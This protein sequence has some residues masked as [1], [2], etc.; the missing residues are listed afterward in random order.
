MKV[1]LMIRINQIK[2]PI[3][4]VCPGGKTEVDPV[5][6][7]WK[8]ETK[9]RE[10]SLLKS[11]AAKLLKCRAKDI[12][13]LRIL[14]RSADARDRQEILFVYSVAVRL[15]D[16]VVGPSADTEKKFIESIR[17]RNIQQETKLPFAA[18]KPDPELIK[19]CPVP[20][21]IIGTGPCGLFAGLILAEAGLKPLILER[22]GT[23]TERVK[24]TE[25]FFDSGHLDPDC[26]IQFGEG[27]AGT[28]S[29]GKLNTSI[30]DQGGFIG[31]VLST[32][33]RFGAD[34]SILYDQ[35]PHIGTDV[36]S[37]IILKIREHIESLGGQY[38]FHARFD[39]IEADALE[40]EPAKRLAAVLYTDTRTG[41]Q[42]RIPCS[43]AVLAIGH[44]ARDTYRVLNESGIFMEPKS[45]AVGI[46]IQHPQRLI[47]EAL[48]GADRLSDK[49][50][51]LG[52]SPYKLTHQAVNGRS[53]YSFCMCPGGH[54]VNSSSEEGRLC[55]NGMSYH[56]RDS[57][58]ANAA[59]IVSVNPEDYQSDAVSGMEALSGTFFQQRLEEAA[60]QA[61]DGVIPY[62]TFGEFKNS[63]TAPSG[64]I[65][66]RDGFF[67]DFEPR[68]K[69]Y[70]AAADVRALLPSY[71]NEALLDGMQAFGKTIP[72][73]DD[74]RAVI[75]GIE[76]RTSSPVRIVRDQDRNALLTP[77]GQD[78]GTDQTPVLQGLY[79][80]GEGAGYAGGITSAAVDGVRTALKVLEQLNS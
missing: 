40:Q 46:R 53:V 75:A 30:K 12:R 48:Y 28:F 9:E 21:V 35:K 29:D 65:S 78:A 71:V 47:D 43:H 59:L 23:V 55:I 49:E 79:P 13:K 10:L 25:L 60:F 57:G 80:A 17:N 39:G 45:F 50:A 2:I 61:A 41:E 19:N 44:S 76:A 37:G 69:G 52:P 15:H 16:S 36:L 63:E 18:P 38:L 24:Q 42:K 8:Q 56:R 1:S 51:V 73:Y 34:E 3:F 7:N 26:N 32:F 72:G 4:E 64:Y 22:G 54:V 62:E 27:G 74:E 5:S 77:D 66:R 6:G 70:A 14:R 58:T 33:V 67:E 20:P 31:Y 11:R 68:F